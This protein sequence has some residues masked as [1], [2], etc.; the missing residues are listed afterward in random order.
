MRDCPACR[1]PL[2]GYEE[3]CPSCGTKQLPP[4]G[5]GG[6]RVPYG[7]SWKPEE[8]RVNMV[9]FVIVFVGV[10]IFL[11]IAMQGT[12]IGGLMRREK[13]APDP[14]E[15]M[16]YTEARSNIDSEI[17]KGLAAVGAKNTKITWHTPSS[18]PQTTGQTD[19]R[20][21]DAPIEL[22]IDTTL[23]SADL[24]KQIIDPIK[25]YMEKAKVFTLNMNDSRSHAHWTYT[26]TP[27]AAPTDPNSDDQ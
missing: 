13:Q 18:A 23:P 24:R 27:G 6:S 22:T 16:T 1:V 19:D 8:P 5:G 21:V 2:H 25:P 20:A 9:P 17:T 14:L 11:V 15:K 12:W 7:A 26:L 3:V 10:A 4:A